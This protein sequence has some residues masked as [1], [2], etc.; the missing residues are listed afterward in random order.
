VQAAGGGRG[1]RW[2]G[3]GITGAGL[4]GASTMETKSEML[5]D[6]KHQVAL[7]DPAPDIGEA[8][9]GC[10]RFAGLAAKACGSKN[11][12]ER[13]RLL[14]ES[15]KLHL[16]PF[17]AVD[18]AAGWAWQVNPL[19]DRSW[20]WR[21]N[22]L[23]FISYLLAHH[24]ATGDLKAVCMAIEAAVSWVG[25]F[26]ASAGPRH[27]FEFAW[28][29]HGTALRAEQIGLL[30]HHVEKHSLWEACGEKG[31]RELLA[32]ACLEH[33][34]MLAT[35][36]FYSRHTNHGLE[37]S[38]VLLM[39]GVAIR[40][41]LPEPAQQWVEIATARINA[42]LRHSFTDE[43]VHVENSPAYHAFV[44]KVFL[45]LIDDYRDAG[46]P[47]LEAWMQE[48][49]PKALDYLSRIIRPDGLLPII[50]DTEALPVTNSFARAFEGTPA[51]LEFLYV[52][53]KG[54]KGRKPGSLHRI[55]PASG[56]AIFRSDWHP[57]AEFSQAMHLVFKA[58]ALSNYHRQQDDGSIVLYAF[59]EDWII[60]SGLYNYDQKSAVRQYMRSRAAHNVWLVDRP[61]TLAQPPEFNW[62]II[63][64]GEGGPV[65]YVHAESGAYEGLRMVRRLSLV[66]RHGFRVDDVLA[67]ADGTP[68]KGESLWHLPA[69]KEVD[70]LGPREIL[71]RSRQSKHRLRI[72]MQGDA[73]AELRLRRGQSSGRVHSVVSTKTGVCTA[74]QVLC[75]MYEPATVLFSS[76]EFNFEHPAPETASS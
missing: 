22:W 29:D 76:I 38:R 72:R 63:A 28:H 44:V 61:P 14:V 40:P 31:A 62:R 53:T 34:Q 43:G 64:S 51:Y 71:V 69:D 8:L 5:A 68:F 6:S 47:E 54:A 58:G 23:S 60:D 12:A 35:D 48:T 16:G 19:A 21:F 57:G 26:P 24:T 55:Y 30:V 17:P 73:P 9:A 49:G 74:S 27:P 41:A 67:C 3:V 2:G 33:G 4:T 42:E 56:Y 39:L 52:Q 20:Q 11:F 65:P 46:L 66:R 13:G 75:V 37:Q 36:R 18:L 32:R 7:R 50:G 59:G 10:A 1:T 25:T 15:R 70:V 45:G